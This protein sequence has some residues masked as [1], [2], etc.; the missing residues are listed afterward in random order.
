MARHARNQKIQ[1]LRGG[2]EMAQGRRK[3][4]RLRNDTNNTIIVCTK[5]YCNYILRSQEGSG[6][7]VEMR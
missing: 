4:N 5:G 3:G 7:E 1:P 6:Q 2:R